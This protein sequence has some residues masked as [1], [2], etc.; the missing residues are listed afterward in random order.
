M[1]RKSE[2]TNDG[3]KYDE[4]EQPSLSPTTQKS[5]PDN[6]S[7]Q[8]VQ[9]EQWVTDTADNLTYNP[10]LVDNVIENEQAEKVRRVLKSKHNS[11]ILI[12]FLNAYYDF[13][14]FRFV[15]I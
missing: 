1:F 5:S 15:R 3:G 13:Q 11:V 6:A 12:F 9:T 8:D 7:L 2:E 4:G 14:Y 10:V